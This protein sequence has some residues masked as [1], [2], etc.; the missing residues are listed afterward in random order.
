MGWLRTMSTPGGVVELCEQG[1]ELFF[2]GFLSGLSGVHGG[3][4][5]GGDGGSGGVLGQARHPGVGVG[6]GQIVDAEMELGSAEGNGP[7]ERDRDAAGAGH[8]AQQLRG[9]DRVVI[10][11]G[12]ER[13]EAGGADL[14]GFKIKGHAR[15]QGRPPVTAH[16]VQLEAGIDAPPL[17]VRED[18]R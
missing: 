4:N 13:V 1:A 8:R 2:V 7:L 12:D 9:G 11:D 18:V 3:L 16:E 5:G 15:H 6:G 10:G 17:V 14:R